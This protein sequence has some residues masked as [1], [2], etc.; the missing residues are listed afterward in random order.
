[1]EITFPMLATTWGPVVAVFALAGLV[2]GVIGLGLPTVAMALLAL[3][4]PP[5]EAAA[6]LLAPSL[7]TNVLQCRP[8]RDAPA[9]LRAT[10]PLQLGL[11]VGTLGVGAWWGAPAGAA[12]GAVL[13]AVLA[14]YAGIGLRGWRWTGAS[15]AGALP[16]GLATG[17][18]TAITGVFVVP[19]VPWLQA[20]IVDRAAL[21]QA[22]GLTFTVAT[23]AL[24]A[25]LALHDALA[26][27][28]VG[29]SLAL[30]VPA[31]LGMTLG[32][33]VRGRLSDT[34]FRRSF[35]GGIGALGLWLMAR[36]WA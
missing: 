7:L 23:L 34:V 1:M 35:F 33:R 5:A 31:L 16:T 4:M 2:K 29:A 17:A 21:V 20:R 28:Q 30:V 3:R 19:A 32:E 27:S 22:L 26:L 13:G 12:A 9:R 25:Q 36:A 18:L 10:W 6:L 8:W 14:L 24:A 11:L 15:P